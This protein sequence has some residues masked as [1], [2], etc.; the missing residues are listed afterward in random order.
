VE[1]KKS[2]LAR[3]RRQLS[4]DGFLFLGG[5]E[6]TLYLDETFEQVYYGKA[7]CCRLRPCVEESQEHAV[8]RW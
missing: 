5:A 4:S 2:I 6:T 1:T 8:A 3:I 7:S